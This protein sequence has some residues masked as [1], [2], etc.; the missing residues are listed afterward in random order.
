ML[1][2]NV[3]IDWL[4]AGAHERWLKGGE[5]VRHLSAVVLMELLAGATTRRAQRAVALIAREHERVGRTVHPSRNAWE[6]AGVVLRRLQASGRD[7]RR[8]SLV[9]DVLIALNAREIGATLVTRDVSDHLAIGQFVDY[10]IVQ[11]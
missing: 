11:A 5:L 2:T 6:G 8:A 9:N 3:Y 10:T 4:N 7:T 1:D